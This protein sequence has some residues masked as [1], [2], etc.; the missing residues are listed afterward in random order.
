MTGLFGFV[1]DFDSSSF[2]GNADLVDTQLRNGDWNKKDVSP[3]DIGP[4]DRR[5]FGDW[6]GLCSGQFCG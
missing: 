4:V 5:S 1:D 3:I 6:G 2:W